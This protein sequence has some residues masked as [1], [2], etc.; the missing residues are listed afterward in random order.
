MAGFSVARC[1]IKLPTGRLLTFLALL[2]QCPVLIQ[3]LRCLQEVS[4]IGE[5]SGGLCFY[6]GCSCGAGKA[7]DECTPQVTWCGVFARVSILGN[8]DT[9]SWTDDKHRTQELQHQLIIMVA[10]EIFAFDRLTSIIL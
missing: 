6:D 7:S 10:I 5:Q 1:H 4:S 2:H 9:R 8:D 3:L